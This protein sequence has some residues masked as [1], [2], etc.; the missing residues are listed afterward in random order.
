VGDEA[1]WG[2]AIVITYLSS[3]ADRDINRVRR[4]LA[5]HY[6]ARTE[7]MLS[8]RLTGEDFLIN[9]PNELSPRDIVNDSHDQ[10]PRQG[11]MVDKFEGEP[12]RRRPT[13]FRVTMHLKNILLKLWSRE[14][15]VRILE[16][17]GE[18]AFIDDATTVSPYRCA[19]YAMVDY[20]DGHMISPRYPG[21]S[22]KI[23]S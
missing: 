16:D 17:L 23:S 15:A 10:T 2:R 3:I 21:A 1:E 22:G 11:I 6:G 8:I 19:I 7:D 13:A 12:E 14:T 18:P 4:Y 9:I 20:H 5:R